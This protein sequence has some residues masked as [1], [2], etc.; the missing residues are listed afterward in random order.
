[1]M[2]DL[3]QP[4]TASIPR[5]PGDPAVDI[6][7]M[8]GTEPWRVS[9]LAMGTHSG[10]HLDAPLHRIPGGAGIGAFGPERFAGTGRVIEARGF[11]E[12]AAIGSEVL[13][14][15]RD[16]VWPGWFAVIRTDWDRYWG[17]DRYFRHPYLSPALARSLRDL[18]TGLAAIDALS[19][20]STVDGGSEAHLTLLS[21]DI[22]I[23][24][25]LR[26]LSLLASDR[27]YA[28]VALPL[29]LGEVDG[30]PARIIAWERGASGL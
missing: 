15:V 20:D 21:A 6:A 1:M 26:N 12:N 27:P 7:T 16:Q 2:I 13:E 5:F 11:G 23:A 3:T 29:A 4:L 22:L 10:T 9:R 25:N 30:S 28:F 14:N 24:E 17:D 19:V 18:G 8:P